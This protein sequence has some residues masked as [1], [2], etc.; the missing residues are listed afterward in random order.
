MRVILSPSSDSGNDPDIAVV[1]RSLAGPE[2]ESVRL[3]DLCEA[4][5][6]RPLSEGEV[7][8]LR[9]ALLGHAPDLLVRNDEAPAPV[10]GYVCVGK[11]VLP[12]GERRVIAVTDHINLAWRSPLTGRNDDRLGPRFPVVAGMYEAELV[13]SRVGPE[14][15]WLVESGVVAG[16]IDDRRLLA[17]ESRMILEQ[18]L[19]A[20]SSELVP[21]ALLAAHLGFRLAAAVVVAREE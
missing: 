12:A 19:A 20:V 15:P 13:S 3:R 18:G 6:R 5:F 2:G 7:Y 1:A 10:V 9:K 21:V 4:A 17:F 14:T 11:T 16:V 8:L